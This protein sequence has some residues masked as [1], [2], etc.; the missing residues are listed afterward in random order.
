MTVKELIEAL[1]KSHSWDAEVNVIDA[2]GDEVAPILLV[3]EDGPDCGDDRQVHIV[4][5]WTG[6]M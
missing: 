6:G 2:N 3:D 1:Q 5:E 4:L